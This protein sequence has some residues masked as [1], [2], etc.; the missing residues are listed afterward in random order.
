METL[1]IIGIVCLIAGFV[2]VGVE[3]V[4]PGFGLPGVSGILC[5]LAGVFLTADSVE[6]A[7]F[8]TI[9][10]IVLLGIL[11]S[12]MLGLLSSGKLKP[13]V[14]LDSEVRG[15][16]GYLNASDLEY[17]LNREGVAATDLHPMGRGVFDGIVLDIY[18]DGSYIEK[19]TPV[20]IA[21]ID[22][23]RLLVKRGKAG[24]AESS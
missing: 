7:V 11:M 4:V 12:V 3:L 18:S 19:G 5:L 13:P 17:L 9:A 2:L 8:I 23:R 16:D 21:R 14:V 22:G 24:G 10:V 20:T 6:E 15:T 1:T